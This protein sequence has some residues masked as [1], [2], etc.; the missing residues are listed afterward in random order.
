MIL[1]ATFQFSL[2]HNTTDNL[3]PKKTHLDPKLTL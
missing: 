1:E 2:F 3:L